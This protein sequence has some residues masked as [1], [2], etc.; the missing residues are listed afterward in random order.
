MDGVFAM[1][2]YTAADTV[3]PCL[4]LIS[5]PQECMPRNPIS[6]A[7]ERLALNQ[8]R[9]KKIPLKNLSSPFF[10]IISRREV[11]S[12]SPRRV[13]RSSLVHERID[14]P[15][16]SRAEHT[17]RTESARSHAVLVA[18]RRDAVRVCIHRR[19]S[20]WVCV[21]AAVLRVG[22]EHAV[23]VRAV[24][25]VVLRHLA[26]LPALVVAIFSVSMTIEIIVRL[27]DA[28]GPCVF[29]RRVVDLRLESSPA[30]VLAAGNDAGFLV[31]V[32]H[33][34]ADCARQTPEEE[35][36][37]AEAD[38]GFGHFALAD[39]AVC[40][41]FALAQGVCVA[42]VGGVV[43]FSLLDA[44]RLPD[45]KRDGACEPEEGEEEVE[46]DVGVDV[47]E[48]PGPRPH[49]NHNLVDQGGDT[50]EALRRWVSGMPS[51][52]VLPEAYKS[53]VE[54]DLAAMVARFGEDSESETAGDKG[55]ES[56]SCVE[57]RLGL[58]IVALFNAHGDGCVVLAAQLRRERLV[59]GQREKERLML[60]S[61]G[62][63]VVVVDVD[64][65]VHLV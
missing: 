4:Y 33:P 30:A 6:S 16:S 20:A 10:S 44:L 13:V 35:D 48:A 52:S 60:I 38:G 42:V 36:D 37:D 61:R 65:Y 18:R 49:G 27:V 7:L 9:S 22:S 21:E 8:I 19:A 34:H 14:L 28:R 47:R 56:L 3:P 11:H 45:A 24:V 15:I 62:V 25:L 64:E 50:E 59:F 57:E 1:F 55:E 2:V 39:A 5:I 58:L 40:P 12:P 32:H 29:A 63:I 23:V 17:S 51:W 46:A 53:E 54:A 26:V 43:F 31:L 41:H